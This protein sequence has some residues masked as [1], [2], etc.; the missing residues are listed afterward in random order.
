MRRRL[1]VAFALIWFAVAANGTTAAA[2]EPP[3]PAIE[4]VITRQLEAFRRDDAAAAF[5]IASPFIQGTFGD[6]GTFVM[7]VERGFRPIRRSERHRFLN[8]DTVE[9]R[10]IQRVLI[11]GAD[12]STAVAR[13]EMIVVDGQWRING[14]ALEKGEAA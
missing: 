4:V 13:Y 12:G 11:D 3:N 1:I 8:L 5:A 9:G 7:M 6:A 10:L 2:A 14:C